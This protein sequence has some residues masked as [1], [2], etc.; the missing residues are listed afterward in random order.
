MLE[1]AWYGLVHARTSGACNHRS[2]SPPAAD[3]GPGQSQPQGV[4]LWLFPR[5]LFL[6]LSLGKCMKPSWDPHEAPDYPNQTLAMVWKNAWHGIDH[7]L[8]LLSTGQ[9]RE[10]SEWGSSRALS[11]PGGP[12]W[13]SACKC[14][15]KL[16]KEE[17]PRGETSGSDAGYEEGCDDDWWRL[18]RWWWWWFDVE[19]WFWCHNIW[20]YLV[21]EWYRLAMRRK[22]ANSD[23]GSKAA[24]PKW[25][26]S[27]CQGEGEKKKTGKKATKGDT[28]LRSLEDYKKKNESDTKSIDFMTSCRF[29]MG[30]PWVAPQKSAEV[31]SG[32]PVAKGVQDALPIDAEQQCPAIF[33]FLSLHLEGSRHVICW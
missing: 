32:D 8:V 5:A 22:V 29:S 14:Q 1:A 10:D 12:R 24:D 33:L 15:V 17:V 28:T 6:D 27:M 19:F 30:F 2:Q 25:S 18:W 4:Q 23:F 7:V 21:D 31:F 11:L 16:N 9:C 26:T 20:I 13:F 3:W